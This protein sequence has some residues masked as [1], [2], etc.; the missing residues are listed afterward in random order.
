MEGDGGSKTKKERMKK[1]NEWEDE[2][3]IIY[4]PKGKN[5]REGG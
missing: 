2:K 5:E 4:H 1:L 3:F